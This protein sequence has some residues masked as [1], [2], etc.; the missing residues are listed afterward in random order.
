MVEE[1]QQTKYD[2]LNNIAYTKLMKACRANAKT[3]N[4]TEKGGFKTAFDIL[5]VIDKIETTLLSWLK[6]HISC[7][8]IL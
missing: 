7:I 3:K 5:H 6:R 2:K 8:I 1:D 4:L